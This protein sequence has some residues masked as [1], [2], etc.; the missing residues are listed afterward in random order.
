VA[1]ARPKALPTANG[2]TIGKLP[3]AAATQN[4]RIWDAANKF[5]GAARKECYSILNQAEYDNNRVI[6]QAITK[7][8]TAL[9]SGRS[10]LHFFST[11]RSPVC[12]GNRK[13]G[14]DRKSQQRWISLFSSTNPG[15]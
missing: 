4:S 5:G 3:L 11:G 13:H 14:Q 12:P 15:P 6:G 2:Q 8:H 1:A 9:P 10:S 7:L